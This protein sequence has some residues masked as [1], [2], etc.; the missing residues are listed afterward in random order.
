M[1]NIVADRS[2]KSL[3][4][5]FLLAVVSA[6]IFV[7]SDTLALNPLPTPA[8]A[9]GS[10]GLEAVKKQP[11]PTQGATISQPGDGQSFGESPVRVNGLCPDGLLVQIYN[12]NVLVGAVMCEG[13][14]YSAEVEV[15]VGE[16]GLQALVFDE[17]G[18]EGPASNTRTVTYNNAR[19]TS[20][21]E[22]ITLTSQFGRRSASVGNNLDWPLQLS[23]GTGPY[24]FSIDWG[25]GGPS[26]LMS[27][28]VSGVLGVNHVYK[29][30]GIYRVNIKVVD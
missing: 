14:S 26:E 17:L 2:W 8:P 13:G 15:F 6:T 16:N 3:T 4:K 12:N 24:A 22:Q 29:K 19:F 9:P 1:K 25:D 7:G 11:A 27:R 10:Y 23:G 18:Q 5:V 30:A 28:P 21:G 20:F